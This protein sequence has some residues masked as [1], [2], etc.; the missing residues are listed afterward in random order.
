MA[1]EDEFGI[2]L[3]GA[4]R[5]GLAPERIRELMAADVSGDWRRI[6]GALELVG[7]LAVNVPGFPKL[8]VREAEGLVASLQVRAYDGGCTSSAL[9]RQIDEAIARRREGLAARIGRTR[10]ARIAALVERVK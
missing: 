2:W 8:R 3:A 5:P 10:E 7:V 9:S 6:G 1:G 4:L